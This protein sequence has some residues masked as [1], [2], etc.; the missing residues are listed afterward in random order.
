MEL[1]PN[2]VRKIGVL[3]S[4]ETLARFGDLGVNG[5]IVIQTATGQQN[6]L[7]RTPRS[8]FVTGITKPRGDRQMIT[9]LTNKRIPILR[10]A[11]YWNPKIEM[12][13]RQSKT[14]NFFTSDDTGFYIIQI[15]GISENGTF[16]SNQLRFSVSNGQ[17]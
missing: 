10:S 8:F 15:N 12:S 3:R 2:D 1:T 14:F 6:K 16:F 7:L 13:E 11:L 4:P 9:E 5:I 17:P